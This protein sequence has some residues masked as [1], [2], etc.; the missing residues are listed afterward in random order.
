MKKTPLTL[1]VAVCAVVVAAPAVAQAPAAEK[2]PPS[3]VVALSEVKATATVEAVDVAKRLLTVKG[4]QGNVETFEVDAAV[5]N[6]PQ[7]QKGDVIVIAYKESLAYEVKKA[8]TGG[9]GIAATGGIV[10]AKPG[11]KPA[12]GAGRQVTA[13]VTITAIDAKAPSVTMKGPGGNERTIKVKDP[14][15]LEGVKV[16]DLVELT[17]TEALAVSVEKA[18]AKK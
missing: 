15:K 8:G 11:E 16:G 14:K 9:P 10:A 5:K 4:P 18:P 6:L 1:V 3:G 7:V 13:V 2:A 12:L 17:Y